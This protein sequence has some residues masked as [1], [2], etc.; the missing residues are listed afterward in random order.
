[1]NI[2]YNNN[3]FLHEK[4]VLKLNDTDTEF[5]TRQLSVT[6]YIHLQANCSKLLKFNG[7]YKKES[8]F[9]ILFKLLPSV[10]IMS[11]ACCLLNDTTTTTSQASIFSCGHK[12]AILLCSVE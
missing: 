10:Y 8:P 2:K 12:N 11:Y 5:G 4:H 3:S 6:F 9:N 7:R 1:M